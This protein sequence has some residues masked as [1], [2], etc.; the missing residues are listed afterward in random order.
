MNYDNGL[1]FC[2]VKRPDGLWIQNGVGAVAVVKVQWPQ[3]ALGLNDENVADLLIRA[4]NRRSRKYYLDGKGKKYLTAKQAAFKHQIN[5]NSLY[6]AIHEK[7]LRATKISGC[8]FLRDADVAEFSATY[9]PRG[10]ESISSE[11][12][13]RYNNGYGESIDVLAKDFGIKR[14]S[15]RAAL[16]R[17]GVKHDSH[18]RVVAHH[19]KKHVMVIGDKRE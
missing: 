13:R 3:L 6:R 8:I 17:E 10:K 18:G 4:L 19:M 5:V 12:A 11:I 2:F 7:R 9:K 14:A 1:E 16:C 15:V